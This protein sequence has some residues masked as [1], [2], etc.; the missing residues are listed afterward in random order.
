MN[1]ENLIQKNFVQTMKTEFNID[2]EEEVQHKISDLPPKYLPK[3]E[4]CK[5]ET[6]TSKQNIHQS[7]GLTKEKTQKSADP[8]F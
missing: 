2:I 8:K 4:Q 1:I 5:A 3:K 7:T 6:T